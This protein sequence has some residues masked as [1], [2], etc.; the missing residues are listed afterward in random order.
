M[1]RIQTDMKLNFLLKSQ[2]RIPIDWSFGK[3][4]KNNIVQ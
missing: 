4:A 2:I 3:K 1:S